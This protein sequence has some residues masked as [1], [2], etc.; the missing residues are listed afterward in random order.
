MVKA[1]FLRS[2]GG[3][4]LGFRLCGHAGGEAGTD[5]VCAAVSSAAY[6]VANTVTEVM[7]IEPG[8][9]YAGDGD[10]SLRLLPKDAARCREL[11]LGLRLHLEGLSQ[12]YPEQ[13]RVEDVSI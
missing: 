10:M 3:A 2:Q 11:L 7:G 4:L 8:E 1:G 12:Q 9:L 13:L 5:I 6:L